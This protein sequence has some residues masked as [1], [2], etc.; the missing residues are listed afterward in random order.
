MPAPFTIH[1]FDEAAEAI[2]ARTAWRPRVAM[3]LGSG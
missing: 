3:I 2:R 1:D